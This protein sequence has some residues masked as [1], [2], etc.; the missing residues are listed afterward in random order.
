MLL[1]NG[2]TPMNS[3]PFNRSTTTCFVRFFPLVPDEHK[4]ERDFQDDQLPNAIRDQ[5]LNLLDVHPH[6]LDNVNQKN[7]HLRMIQNLHPN[8]HIAF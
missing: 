5:D 2:H 3:Q 7:T 6:P 1:K 4:E 8:H